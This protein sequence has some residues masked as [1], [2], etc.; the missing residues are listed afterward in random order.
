LAFVIYFA[1]VGALKEFIEAFLV[2]NA[3]YTVSSPLLFN[4]P[5]KWAQ[6]HAYGITLWVFLAGLTALVILTFVALWRG[7]WRAPARIPIAAVGAASFA[8]I[9]WSF[10]DFNSWP[11]AFVLLPL[12]A[13]GI[14]GIAKELIDRLPAKAPLVICLAWAVASV[15]VATTY[16]LT[17]QGHAL[18]RQRAQVARILDI[19]G[20]DISMQ[21]IGAP[22]PL[23][24]SGKRNPTRHQ[25][26]VDGLNEY[27][28]DT[29]PGGLRGFARWVGRQE[30]TIL[31]LNKGVPRWLRGTIEREYRWAGP[32]TGWTWY[33]HRSRTP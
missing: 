20:P 12:A 7:G 5:R 22:G 3:R 33:V 27:I 6:M 26:F 30:P 32:A 17:R 29:W 8:G 4:L 23:V 10:R 24:L 2:I 1:L 11:D 31:A 9:A 21:S 14:G 13:V 16:S 15:A 25:T 18:P 19:L 28:N